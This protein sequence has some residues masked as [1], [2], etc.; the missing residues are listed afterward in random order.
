M[1]TVYGVLSTCL[2]RYALVCV[3][4][5]CLLP[6]L[7]RALELV[8]VGTHLIWYILTYCPTWQLQCGVVSYEIPTVVLWTGKVCL[9]DSNVRSETNV[10]G[11]MAGSKSRTWATKKCAP[12]RRHSASGTQNKGPGFIHW[13]LAHGSWFCK[14]QQ[15]GRIRNKVFQP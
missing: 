8:L 15:P 6:A 1:K 11:T 7:V 12:L 13:Y 9:L 2:C 4:Q 14:I 10:P 5:R 3:L